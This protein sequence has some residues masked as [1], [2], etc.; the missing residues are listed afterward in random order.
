MVPE[1]YTREYS[2]VFLSATI[3]ITLSLPTITAPI[4]LSAFAPLIFY[5]GDQRQLLTHSIGRHSGLTDM[6]QSK[7]KRY[8]I[9]PPKLPARELRS[10]FGSLFPSPCEI[11]YRCLIIPLIFY[12]RSDVGIFTALTR[13]EEVRQSKSLQPVIINNKRN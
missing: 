8:R 2:Q 12:F 1:N 13:L 3:G 9:N 6:P 4:W 7:P 10:L 11:Q 5:I